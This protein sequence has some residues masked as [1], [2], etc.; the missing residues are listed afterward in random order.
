[1][2]NRT[3]E[4]LK[5]M[6]IRHKDLAKKLGITVIAMSQMLNKPQPKISTLEAVAKAIGVPTWKLFLTDE[7]I[8]EIVAESFA[9]MNSFQTTRPLASS[10]TD[11]Y[12]V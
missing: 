12:Y 4:V 6:N 11:F 10:D 7:E 9:F 2:E 8:N 3:R 1:M 5:S